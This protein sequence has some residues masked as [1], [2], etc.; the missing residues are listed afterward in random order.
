MDA[1]RT[2]IC[3]T[4]CDTRILTAANVLE[5]RRAVARNTRLPRTGGG[6][7]S[8]IRMNGSGDEGTHSGLEDSVTANAGP[9]LGPH[10]VARRWT[11]R[12]VDPR[13]DPG[14]LSNDKHLGV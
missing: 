4:V 7:C 12:R 1:R 8:W 6:T 14:I 3:R 13:I 2:R 10:E 9:I 5:W 11:G